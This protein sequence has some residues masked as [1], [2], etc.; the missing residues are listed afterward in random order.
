MLSAAALP[1]MSQAAVAAAACFLLL[2]G[3]PLLEGGLGVKLA[4]SI[5]P[6]ADFLSLLARAAAVQE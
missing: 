2:L 6:I 5:V 1:V 4:V 3:T